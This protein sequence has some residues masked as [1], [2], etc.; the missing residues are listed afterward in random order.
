MNLSDSYISSPAACS[1]I[2]SPFC[3]RSVSPQH[4]IQIKL[5]FF[6]LLTKEVIWCKASQMDIVYIGC[7]VGSEDTTYSFHVG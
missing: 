6:P 1:V 7:V 5:H 2:S 4:F 3:S